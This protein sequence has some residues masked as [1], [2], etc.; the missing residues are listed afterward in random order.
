LTDGQVGNE[1]QVMSL[2]RSA[3]GTTRFFA[4]GIGAGPNDHL[5]K[6]LARAGGGAAAFIFPGERIEPRV[7]GIFRQ[8]A[9][10][11]VTGVHVEWGA[12]AGGTPATTPAAPALLP[13]EATSLFARLVPGAASPPAVTVFAEID[14]R[15]ARWELPVVEAGAGT[16]AL[17]SLWA[18]SRIRDLEETHEAAGRGSRQDR[19]KGDGWKAEI[20]AL[21]KEF[22]LSSSQTS[23]IAVEERTDKQSGEIVLRKVP[24]LVTA[25]WHGR[26]SVLGATMARSALGNV[27]MGKRAAP[28][29]RRDSSAAP[30]HLPQ[31]PCESSPV[32]YLERRTMFHDSSIS[33]GD[34][35]AGTDLLVDLLAFQRVD[36][37]FD[38]DKAMLDR[39]GIK[40]AAV[41]AAARGLPGESDVARRA[42]HTAIV[43]AVLEARLADER[44]TWFAAVRKSRTWL[45]KTAGA[46]GAA[47]SGKTVEQW[48]DE[49]VGRSSPIARS[50][51]Y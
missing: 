32:D 26:G 38:L 35:Q 31:V 1:A 44:S 51:G 5:V 18:R 41:T 46:W 20:V 2:V 19:P 21:A 50:D 14:G 43:L 45:K 22:G 29:P 30:A 48:A 9:G 49:I 24:S 36:G 17:P 40:S 4:V 7:L 15:P 34:E 6:G 10:P 12:V 37:G 11:R 28:G 27:A 16:V 39:L 13:G 8:A 33:F 3:A 25:G 42:L 23:W 47:I